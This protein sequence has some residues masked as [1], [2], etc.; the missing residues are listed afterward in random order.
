MKQRIFD[1]ISSLIALLILAPVA[2]LAWP[3]L[4]FLVGSPIVFRQKRTGLRGQVFVMYKL[5]SMY[6]NAESTKTRHLELNEAPW[7]MF[8]ISADPRFVR[9]GNLEIGRFLSRSG[10]DE[11]PQL[12]NVLRG[13]MSLVGPRPLPVSEAEALNKQDPTWYRWRHSVRPGI[14]SLWAFDSQHNKS[15]AHWRRLE[16]ATLRLSLKEQLTVIGKIILK[17]LKN[18]SK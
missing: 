12:W 16:K 18:L 14:F 15:L 8:K 3:I 5:R 7:P 13:E 17:Q 6:R 1:L 11:L 4:L 9:K 2:L 10:L